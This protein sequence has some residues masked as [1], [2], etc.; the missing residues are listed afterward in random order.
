MGAD[1]NARKEPSAF[2]NSAGDS[3]STA[4]KSEDSWAGYASPQAR[5]QQ[6]NGHSPEDN[7]EPDAGAKPS[8]AGRRTDPWAAANPW[9]G[10]AAWVSPSKAKITEETASEMPGS[11]EVT[12][13]I[14]A[15]AVAAE[16]TPLETAELEEQE[17]VEP[18]ADGGVAEKVE[19]L[20]PATCNGVDMPSED[21]QR[22]PPPPRRAPP[23]SSAGDADSRS[24]DQQVGP[25]P[26]KAISPAVTIPDAPPPR[27]CAQAPPAP[28]SRAP[29]PLQAAAPAPAAAVASPATEVSD[30]LPARSLRAT[31]V[32]VTAEAEESSPGDHVCEDPDAQAP[33][34]L[35]GR[36]KVFYNDQDFGF[37]RCHRVSEN[38]FVRGGDIIGGPPAGDSDLPEVEFELEQQQARRPRAV[39]VRLLA[40]PPASGSLSRGLASSRGGSIG[41]MA[42]DR[43][44]RTPLD[45][46]GTPTRST[47]AGYSPSTQTRREPRGGNAMIDA[48]DLARRGAGERVRG[49]L[50]SFAPEN[51][52]GFIVCDALSVD[53]FVHANSFVGRQPEAII[54]PPDGMPLGPEVEFNL[55]PGARPKALNTVILGPCTTQDAHAGAPSEESA[56]PPATHDTK[57]PIELADT[58]ATCLRHLP[59]DAPSAVRAY[60]N[61]WVRSLEPGP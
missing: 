54:S 59:D 37:I 24:G 48:V 34:R 60:L 11:P 3:V 55:V 2:T 25:P 15:A 44:S 8:Q 36:L 58:V 12:E 52:Y 26:P 20:P 7:S 19:K 35:R 5:K 56:S 14:E 45:R 30:T 27:P 43:G 57:E 49:M 32:S 53:V 13:A 9:G 6:P 16:R 39:K 31:P 33:S 38:V 46:R 21:V 50:K 40:P 61:Y 17:E 42:D 23:P 28:P 22:L 41:A 4:K 18:K 29:P 10:C 1:L 47:A 51:R